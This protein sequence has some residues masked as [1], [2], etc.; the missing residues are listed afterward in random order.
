MT[1]IT[2][3]KQD[4]TNFCFD[5]ISINGRKQSAMRI[6][7]IKKV[8]SGKWIGKASGYDFTVFGGRDAGGASNEWFVQWALDGEHDFIKYDSAKAAINHIELS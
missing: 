2:F 3:K 4:M 7:S 6:T 8:G 1:N 5:T